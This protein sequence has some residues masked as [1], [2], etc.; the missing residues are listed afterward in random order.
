MAILSIFFLPFFPVCS[1]PSWKCE[2][3]SFGVFSSC[4]HS[5]E[6]PVWRRGHLSKEETRG[7][8]SNKDHFAQENSSC[9]ETSLRGHQS[10]LLVV[11]ST[12]PGPEKEVN[13]AMGRRRMWRE[14]RRA[15]KTSRQ[16][17]QVP[18]HPRGSGA[19]API[20]VGPLDLDLAGTSV[21]QRPARRRSSSLAKNQ[22]CKARVR[23]EFSAQLGAYR[24]AGGRTCDHLGEPLGDWRISVACTM[25]SVLCLM[26]LTLRSLKISKNA[27]IMP[28]WKI[29]PTSIFK[30]QTRF[31]NAKFV[32]S[33]IEKC[34][35][36]TL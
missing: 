24:R 17:G 13:F 9:G 11:S 32:K 21:Y 16:P 4:H 34:Q 23:G 36:A 28:D 18:P 31:K 33:G 26:N 6:L 29:M 1:G 30:C 14:V 19:E 15:L 7:E 2:W 10:L 22:S 8:N 25:I 12:V 3:G 27:T 20:K 5:K 35:L